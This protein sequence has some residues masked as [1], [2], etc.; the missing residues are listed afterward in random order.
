MRPRAKDF[1]FHLVMIAATAASVLMAVEPE[2]ALTPLRY[3]RIFV[4]AEE[5]NAQAK[6]MIPL[7]REEFERR[8]LALVAR[9]P[10]SL[11]AQVRVENA[12]YSARLSGDQLVDGNARLEV[13]STTTEAAQLPWESTLPLGKPIWDEQPPRPAR[14]GSTQDGKSVLIVE[15]SG[16]MS[17]PWTLQGKTTDT[18]GPTFD[19]VL[20]KAAISR[21][22]LQ[23]PAGLTPETDFGIVSR[24]DPGAP[25]NQVLPASANSLSANWLVELGGL[26]QVRLRAKNSVKA[27]GKGIVLVRES[28]THVLS[29]VD[30]SSELE[31]QLEVH[32][33]S[34]RTLKLD[35]DAPGRV[36]GVRVGGTPVSWRETTSGKGQTALQ[37]ELPEGLT[38]S[39][40]GLTVSAVSPLTFDSPWRLP[41]LRLAG[42]T[43]QEGIATLVVPPALQ[44]GPLQLSDVRQTSVSS[45]SLTQPERTFQFQYLSSLGHVNLQPA[46]DRPLLK[47]MGGLVV[48]HESTQLAALLNLDLTVNFG[49]RFDLEGITSD[50]WIIDS[51]ETSPNDLLEER[52]FVPQEGRRV[53]LRLRLSRPLTSKEPTRLVI[54]AHRPVPAEGASLTA[55]GLRLLEFQDVLDQQLV[56]ALRATDSSHEFQL[57]GDL[58][59]FRI[60]P[61][62]AAPEELGLLDASAAGTMFRLDRQAE[63]A[64]ISLVPSDPR[65]TASIESLALAQRGRISHSVIARITP[66]SSSLTRLLVRSSRPVPAALRWKLSGSGDLR[67]ESQTLL[68]ATAG[69]EG[70]KESI[71][72]LVLSRVTTQPLALEA[73]WETSFSQGESL[74]LF[75]FPEAA[76]Q[77][78]VMRVETEQGTPARLET[79]GVKAIPTPLAPAGNYS[80]VRGLF[81]FE[82]GRQAS[83][84]LFT[85]AKDTAPE[86]AWVRRCTLHSRYAPGGAAT[87]EIVWQLE[88]HGLDRF[89]FSL[90]SGVRPLQITVDEHDT[91]MPLVDSATGLHHVPLPEKRRYPK[92]SLVVSTRA[93]ESSWMLQQQWSAPLVTTTLSVLER[94]WKVELP[95]GIV[96]A[97]TEGTDSREED[98]QGIWRS[99]VCGVFGSSFG[100]P[101]TTESAFESAWSE[102][103]PLSVSVHAPRV[104]QIWGIS[105]AVATAC[106]VIRFFS[107]TPIL[108]LVA[109]TLFACGALLAPSAWSSLAAGIFWGAVAGSLFC[110]IRP[111]SLSR[112]APSRQLLPS[113]KATMAAGVSGVLL[114]MAAMTAPERIASAAPTDGGGTEPTA[115]HRVIIPVDSNQQPQGDYVYVSPEFYKLLYRAPEREQLPTWLLRSATYEMQP[116]EQGSAANI[117]MRIELETVTRAAK[118]A[119]PLRRGEIHLL[120]G[121]AMLDGQPVLLDWDDDGGSLRMEIDRP[122]L[123]Q[124]SLSFSAA[125]KQEGGLTRWSLTVPKSPR[126]Q[127]LIKSPVRPEDWLVE[128]QRIVSN[129]ESNGDVQ[130]KL[131]PAGILEIS[132]KDQGRVADNTMEADQFLWWKVRPGSVTADAVFRF[133]PTTGK[134]SEIKLLADTQLRLLPL[135][136]EPQISRVWVEEGEPNIIHLVL[137]E[138]TAEPFELNG[139]F[140]LLG[141]SGIGKLTLPRLAAATDRKGLHWQAISVGKESE[142]SPDPQV[143][144]VSQPPVEFVDHFGGAARPPNVSFEAS[145]QSPVFLIRPREGIVRAKET[146][147]VCL[148]LH[149]AEI[150]YRADLANIP[151][152]RFQEL[153]E[154]P[155][156]FRVAQ[157]LLHEQEAPVSLGWPAIH[158]GTLAIHR[159]QSPAG[160]QQLVIDGTLPLAALAGQP[161]LI[162]LPRLKGVARDGATVRIYRTPA[163]RPVI[164]SA[165]ELLRSAAPEGAAWEPQLGY[166][167]ASYKSPPDAQLAA[168]GSDQGPALAITVVV[169]PNSPTTSYRLVTKMERTAPRAWSAAVNCEITSESGSL[170]A[171]RFEIPP[172]WSGPFEFTPAMDHQVVLLPGQTQRHLVIR[173]SQSGKLAF[174][175]RGPLKLQTGESP[176]APAVLPLDAARVDSFLLLPR[177]AADENLQWQ[178]NGLQALAANESKE[179]QLAAA[180]HEAFRV[181]ASHF[182][183]T[184]QSKPLRQNARIVLSD[185]LLST[186][187]AG[188][189]AARAICYLLPGGTEE[190]AFQLPSGCELVGVLVNDAV[191]ECRGQGDGPWKVRLGHQQLPQVVVVIYD[192]HQNGRFSGNSPLPSPS[193]LGI[194]IEKSN[195]T[196]WE[197]GKSSFLGSDMPQQPENPDEFRTAALSRMATVIQVVRGTGDTV[198]SG[199]LPQ[200]L[201]AWLSVWRLEFAQASQAATP[202]IQPSIQNADL[203]NEPLDLKRRSLEE[204]FAATLGRFS[205]LR[206][207]SA[208]PSPGPAIFSAKGDKPGVNSADKIAPNFSARYYSADFYLRLAMAVSLFLLAVA[209]ACLLSR[210]K[211][212]IASSPAFAL[213]IAANF[214][215]LLPI[216]GPIIVALL[217]AAAV[218]FSLRPSWH[219]AKSAGSSR[220]FRSST[221]SGPT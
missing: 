5:L 153:V 119:I 171:A 162:R 7:K 45:G 21:L 83:I 92:V 60:D 211:E 130:V 138:P 187:P 18:E 122:G 66:T 43:W 141:A 95:P 27:A 174:S 209:A 189:Y 133:R 104:L 28:A 88:N 17:V 39:R 76:A 160:S 151:P 121:R 51:V 40:F 96:R 156:G 64:S 8:V 23:V 59:L 181:V 77:E 50:Q 86:L 152:H 111:L 107:A 168:P 89:S 142:I 56:V 47:I 196:L 73:D 53:S 178:T 87:H 195:W 72:E 164:Q 15:K 1:C 6:G 176:H 154:L 214:A 139:K 41:R 193:W 221:L 186:R 26:A 57:S 68:P 84:N 201:A 205:D 19:L 146:I 9:Q 33:S 75:S 94:R 16:T 140:L 42:G 25:E 127:L 207:A 116:P 112:P 44:I 10:N 91:A 165:G 124:L 108:V 90:P 74:P 125:G 54:R 191:A 188:G 182:A 217:A 105:L 38:G 58:D 179:L 71:W 11:A 144:M 118:I 12:T 63:G 32:E 2:L 14:L 113:T 115:I 69:A 61:E 183:A 135:E 70:P 192:Q 163:S 48:R 129:V 99:R 79:E 161:E 110:L 3:R 36:T 49:E 170:D 208:P 24:L 117:L 167:L 219:S 37:V 78:G 101:Q 137:A 52:Q 200:Q 29:P 172:E 80:L 55:A 34:L 173:P 147:D 81:R 67:I 184:L 203:E 136:N 31:L 198:V 197:P 175:V 82:P 169:Q 4:A 143:P 22:V 148:G 220:S 215:L 155:A 218:W 157:A 132:R 213:I 202:A 93:P 204:E 120:E 85:P 166:L 126:S 100:N 62:S 210:L 185:V 150:R 103:E 216:G 159:A 46:R 97:N 212:L 106:L 35:L 128:A 158:A 149:D 134:I 109:G 30:A 199:V 123:Y 194:P 206:A 190:A 180:G 145:E 114:I 131:G 13:V 98:W 102:S 20:P 65:F 177:Q